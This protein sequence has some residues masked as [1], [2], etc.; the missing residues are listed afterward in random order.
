M[1]T[2]VSR[3][4][5]PNMKRWQQICNT[6]RWGNK[7]HTSW[8]GVK[9]INT[10][11]HRAD[12]CRLLCVSSEVTSME[13]QTLISIHFKSGSLAWWQNRLLKYALKRHTESGSHYTI[14]YY[15]K[16]LLAVLILVLLKTGPY[17]AS[18]KSEIKVNHV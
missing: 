7:Y 15:L 18:L 9:C 13:R 3:Y 5:N 14:M 12:A 2:I 8:K 17:H 16:L 4:M 10:T 1:C 6:T 11:K